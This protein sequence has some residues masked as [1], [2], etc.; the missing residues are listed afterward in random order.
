MGAWLG[1]SLATAEAAQREGPGF[2]ALA[3]SAIAARRRDYHVLESIPGLYYG[4]L[5]ALFE[6]ADPAAPDFMR[7]EAWQRKSLQTALSGWAQLRHTWELQA[8]FNEL[9]FGITIRP[10]GFVEPDPEFFRRMGGMAGFIVD[11]LMAAGAFY[12]LPS[13]PDDGPPLG[14]SLWRR[15]HD[16]EGLAARLEVLSQKQL[17]GLDWEPADA[18]VLKDYGNTMGHIMGYE[19]DAVDAPKD[20]APRWTTVAH[21]PWSDRNLAVATGRPR[22]LY[23]LYPWKGTRILCCGA[24]MPYYEYAA[25]GRLTDPEWKAKLDSPAPPAQPGW[26]QPLLPPLGR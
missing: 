26:V 12:D 22:A 21:D 10:A 2:E 4:A 5:S 7:G 11:R 20:D 18:G 8:K 24:V 13:D 3:G 6:P 25:P 16:F 14:Q 19:S 17:R 23:V 9:Y 1:S 15:W